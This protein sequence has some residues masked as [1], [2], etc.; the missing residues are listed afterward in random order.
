MIIILRE[1]FESLLYENYDEESRIV[2]DI[3]KLSSNFFLKDLRK[4]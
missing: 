3:E 4:D 1:L 2:C